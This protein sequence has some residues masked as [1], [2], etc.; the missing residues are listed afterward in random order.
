VQSSGVTVR[1]K[2][3]GVAEA[4]GGGTTA[5]STDG[6]V[7]YTPTQAETNYTSFVL[8]AKKTGCI[9]ASVTVVT[10]ASATAGYAGVDWSKVTAS[11]ST[12]NLSS[13][14]ISASQVVASVSGAVG[15]VTG[16]VGSVTGAVGSVT[17]PVTVGTNND[18]TGYSLATA[19]PTA[20]A[21]ADAVWDEAYSGHT[22]AGT[23]GKLM[24]ILRKS[25]T[26][27]EGTILA[28]PTPTTTAFRISGADYPTGALAG[29]VLWMN[30]GASQEQNSPIISTLNNGDGTI[31][32]TLENALVTAPSA[33]DTVLIDPTS[34]VHSVAEIQS[35]L[36]TAANL[37]IAIDRVS[38]C[39]SALAGNCSDAQTAAE[40][41][42]LSIGGNTYTVDYSGLDAS[43]NRSTTTLSKA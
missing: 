22:T 32:V 40:T 29:S 18:K 17:S 2:P 28:S 6:V 43:G 25:N 16:A 7:L 34:H 27:I 23:F 33:G 5:Y 11:T 21:I 4:D 31:T 39:L 9:P 14:T 1:I 36:A 30:S 12:V 8:I 10:T 24:D 15:S 37:L 20:A 42:I 3:V 38:Y 35:G 13:T 19:P 41:Y 26:V